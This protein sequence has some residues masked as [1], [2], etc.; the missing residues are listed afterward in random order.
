[1]G[2][3]VKLQKIGSFTVKQPLIKTLNDI[4][5]N[6][7]LKCRIEILTKDERSLILYTLTSVCI[8]LHTVL[9]T[10]PK[11]PARR[12]WLTIDC[13]FSCWS[14]LFF[15]W[16]QCLI[17]G[18]YCEEKIAGFLS[19]L[20]FKGYRWFKFNSEKNKQGKTN[21]WLNSAFLF[22]LVPEVQVFPTNLVQL[23]DSS[24]HSLTHFTTKRSFA[25][26]CIHTD[27]VLC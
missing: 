16:L 7:P 18:W 4:Y 21:D 27:N 6:H 9:Y 11:V 8:V 19:R 13:I 26:S 17:Q 23:A 22:H 25:L 1:M 3:S 10:F 12:I 20:G 24:E 14:F 2:R 15:W 5:E